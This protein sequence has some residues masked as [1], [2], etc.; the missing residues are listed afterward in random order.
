M[1][2]ASK[3]S[4][5]AAM[6]AGFDTTAARTPWMR[7]FL[8]YDPLPTARRVRQPVLILQGATDQQ[9]RPEEARMLDKALREAGNRDVTLRIFEDRNHLFLQDSVGHPSGYASL[10]NGKVD[11]E[12]LG[13]LADWLAQQLR[14]R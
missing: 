6:H 8:A 13:V 12:V 14:S 1:P 2:A 7:Y 3:D 11:A 9:V 5:L 4:I 10:T